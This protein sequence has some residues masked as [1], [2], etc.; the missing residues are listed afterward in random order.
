MKEGQPYITV[1]VRIQREGEHFSAHCVELGTA[2]CGETLDEAF[3][4]IKEAV[5]VHLNAL[6]KLGERPRF[7]KEHGIRVK[8]YHEPGRRVAFQR[9]VYTDT[10]TTTCNIPVPAS[11]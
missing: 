2:S 5:Q 9:K 10:L 8:S 11:A 7:F 3:E 4:N 1:T 6:E